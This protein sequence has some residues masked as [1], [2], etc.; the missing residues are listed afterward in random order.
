MRRYGHLHYVSKRM[1]YAVLYCDNEKVEWT[2]NELR[3]LKCVKNI[4]RSHLQEIKTTYE[5]KKKKRRER[6]S[7]HLL[8]EYCNFLGRRK[9]A[10]PII[11]F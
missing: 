1:K 8:I 6:G 3:Q 2:I 7:F 5:K 11:V 9:C 4:E 10:I